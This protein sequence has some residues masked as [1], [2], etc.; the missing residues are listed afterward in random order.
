MNK[1]NIPSGRNGIQIWKDAQLL[2]IE[3]VGVSTSNDYF[4]F[5]CNGNRPLLTGAAYLSSS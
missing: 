2:T 3:G 5:L 1:A 4:P